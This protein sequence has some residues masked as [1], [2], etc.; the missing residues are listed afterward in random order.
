MITFTVKVLRNHSGCIV[1]LF[2]LITPTEAK[3][4]QGNNHEYLQS[5]FRHLYDFVTNGQAADCII[6]RRAA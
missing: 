3:S 2:A 1:A 5:K 4:K 6:E